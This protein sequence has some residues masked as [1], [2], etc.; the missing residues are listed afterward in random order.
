MPNFNGSSLQIRKYFACFYNSN[1][2]LHSEN[3]KIPR[4]E[5]PDFWKMLFGN[6][7]IPEVNLNLVLSLGN[8]EFGHKVIEINPFNE[9]DEICDE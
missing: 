6:F 9:N 4:I 3:F 7:N 2:N 5:F 8:L 1:K